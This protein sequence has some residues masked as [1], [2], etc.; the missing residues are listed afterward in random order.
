MTQQRY[1]K[2]LKR[3][4]RNELFG[5][6]LYAMAAR[7]ARHS[8]H[9]RKWEALRDLETRMKL[10]LSTA[11]AR[12]DVTVPERIAPWVGATLGVFAGLLPWRMIMTILALITRSS[13]PFFERVELE[14]ATRQGSRLDG[15][16]A[17]ERAQ[18]EFAR[19]ELAHDSQHSLQPVLALLLFWV[20]RFRLVERMSSRRLA[21]DGHFYTTG[22]LGAERAVSGE[23]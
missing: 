6:A 20:E 17:H 10:Q 8:G 23:E 7:V 1:V 3:A 21:A 15:L 11:L 9:R 12:T 5:E 14:A 19:R 22:R 13:T 18:C 2:K 16:G 4:Y